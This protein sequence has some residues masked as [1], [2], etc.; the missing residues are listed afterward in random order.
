[1]K[2]Y[3]GLILVL[4]LFACSLSVSAVLNCTL[5]TSCESTT[6][7]FRYELNGGT[8][9]HF[10]NATGVFNQFLC[11]RSTA[12]AIIQSNQCTSPRSDVF[13]KLFDWNNTHAEL[14]SQ[15][16][17]GKSMCFDS[18]TAH[19]RCNER[20]SPC[21]ARETCVASLHASTNSHVAS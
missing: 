16:N 3:R 18:P 9:A 21:E 10:H 5:S 2:G 14:P 1:M 20:T 15:A 17:Y 12:A 7:N 8:N 4:F 11:C 19:Y 13:L 6:R